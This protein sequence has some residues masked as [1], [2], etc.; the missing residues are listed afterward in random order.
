[1]TKPSSQ[2]IRLKAFIRA[3]IRIPRKSRD[4]ATPPQMAPWRQIRFA[5]TRGSLNE[6][7]QRSLQERHPGQ[8]SLPSLL[9]VEK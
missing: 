6:E 2:K 7:G 1:M 8:L 4:T 9:V 3:K 5:V